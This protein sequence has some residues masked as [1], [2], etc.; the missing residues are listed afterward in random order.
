MFLTIPTVYPFFMFPKNR[1]TGTV[2]DFV[3][4]PSVLQSFCPS[5][6]LS[7]RLPRPPLWNIER[8]IL[9]IGGVP[10]PMKALASRYNS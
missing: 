10:R 8:A 6:R 7:V 4:R 1:Q 2:N 9:W 5:V 3:V